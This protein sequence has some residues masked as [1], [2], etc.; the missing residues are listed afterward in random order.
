M[1]LNYSGVNRLVRVPSITIEL[2]GIDHLHFVGSFLAA[3]IV[4][5][6]VVFHFLDSE[7]DISFKWSP[8]GEGL[9]KC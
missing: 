1:K 6:Y 2:F 7:L 4:D 5:T 8:K 9:K 3:L